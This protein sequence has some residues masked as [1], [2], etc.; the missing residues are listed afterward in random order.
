VIVDRNGQNFFGALLADYIL[1]KMLDDGARAGDGA[2]VC[3]CGLARANGFAQSFFGQNLGSQQH[4]LIADKDIAW[5]FDEPVN[6]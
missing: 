2:G 4:A 3:R 6:F 1:I 5:P